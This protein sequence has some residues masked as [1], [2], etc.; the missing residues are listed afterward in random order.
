M[1]SGQQSGMGAPA[2]SVTHTTT[3]TWRPLTQQASVK[4]EQQEEKRVTRSLSRVQQQ[5]QLSQPQLQAAS[6]SASF[7]PAPSP[8]A[9]LI[10]QPVPGFDTVPKFEPST[11]KQSTAPVPSM[12]GKFK[13]FASWMRSSPT[14]V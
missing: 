8:F 7:V 1:S 12:W 10:R 4:S 2:F 14:P 9:A 11:F 6:A 13:K 5:H 3:T